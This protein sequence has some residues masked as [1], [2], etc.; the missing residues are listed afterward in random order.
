MVAKQQEA[1]HTRTDLKS[2]F[3]Q[4]I[5]MIRFSKLTEMFRIFDDSKF[6]LEWEI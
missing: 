1:V 3:R 6:K 4:D 2:A 5:Q